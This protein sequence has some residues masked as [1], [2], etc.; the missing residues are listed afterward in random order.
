MSSFR[1]PAPPPTVMWKV[2]VSHVADSDHPQHHLQE[3][4]PSEPRVGRTLPAG[5]RVY[6][7]PVTAAGA[8]G[9][10]S[11]PSDLYEGGERRALGNAEDLGHSLSDGE[12]N[13]RRGG[14]GPDRER[15]RGPGVGRVSG[16]SLSCFSPALALRCPGGA[17]WIR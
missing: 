5:G 8:A 13:L 9:T 11:S 2:T 3:W 14:A 15:R 7:L 16:C 6:S 17:P 1:V 12:G 10:L 4:R